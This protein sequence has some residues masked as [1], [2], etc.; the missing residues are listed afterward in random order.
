MEIS[1]DPNSKN[2]NKN[3][4]TK[5]TLT[6]DIDTRRKSYKSETLS[7]MDDIRNEEESK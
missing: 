1:E 4:H 6:V 2:K 3:I 7:L 5:N